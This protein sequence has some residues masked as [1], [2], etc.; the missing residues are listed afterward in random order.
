MLRVIKKI[1]LRLGKDWIK[2]S[3]LSDFF[4]RVAVN[5]EKKTKKYI[6]VF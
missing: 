2:A 5:M 6:N 3:K 1:D 4:V